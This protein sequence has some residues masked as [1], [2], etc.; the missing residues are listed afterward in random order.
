MLFIGMKG[1]TMKRIN[2]D[3]D[4]FRQDMRTGKIWNVNRTYHLYMGGGVWISSTGDKIRKT[5]EEFDKIFE[6][7]GE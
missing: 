2:D 1:N 6:M 3:W 4:D 7:E 5:L